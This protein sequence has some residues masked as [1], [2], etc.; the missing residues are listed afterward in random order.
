MDNSD[1]ISHSINDEI[2]NK[3]KFLEGSMIHN[4]KG[5][6]MGHINGTQRLS[7]RIKDS[8]YTIIDYF[9]E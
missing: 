7:Y 6:V 9:V 4:I 3:G 5:K 1:A 8:S 2:D